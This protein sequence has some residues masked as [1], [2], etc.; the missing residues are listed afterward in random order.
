M[1]P[2]YAVNWSQQAFPLLHLIQN[3]FCW[4]AQ[5]EPTLRLSLDCSLLKFLISFYTS[6]S[7]EK[8]Q[9]TLASHT[10]NQKRKAAK[11]NERR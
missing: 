11:K 8:P 1:D 9:G 6:C 5:H 4:D 10:V 7:A 3:Y 2:E